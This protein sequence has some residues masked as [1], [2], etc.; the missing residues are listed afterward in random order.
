M[1]LSFKMELTFDQYMEIFNFQVKYNEQYI[2]I[3]ELALF[4]KRIKEK[5]D[6]VYPDELTNL[7]KTNEYCRELENVQKNIYNN[8]I[9]N[10]LASKRHNYFLTMAD[11]TYKYRHEKEYMHYMI[12][13]I[14]NYINNLDNSYEKF[15]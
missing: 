2:S 7:I 1:L 9:F 6:N 5:M 12:N 14:H 11:T 13:T 10:R 8:S 4:D 15:L 3:K